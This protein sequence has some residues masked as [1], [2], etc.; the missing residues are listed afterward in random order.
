MNS[1]YNLS[2]FESEKVHEPL[3]AL[4]LKTFF[5]SVVN[6]YH[7]NLQQVQSM[8]LLT[9]SVTHRL[10]LEVTHHTKKKE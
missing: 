4:V 5:F 6:K 2:E 9:A 10:V 7:F 1:S 3:Q 8:D